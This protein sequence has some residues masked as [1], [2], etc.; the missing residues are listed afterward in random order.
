MFLLTD[1]TVMVQVLGVGAAGS[2]DWW[3]LTPDSSGSYVDG[4]WSQVGSLPADYGPGAYAAA[5][6]PDGR[7]AV[8]GGEFNNDVP[9]ESNL[10]A[11]YDPLTNTWT[12]VSPPNGGTGFWANI[13]DAPSEVLAD[14]RWLVGTAVSADYA[15]LDPATLTWTS[16][17]GGSK[18]DGN[19]EAGFTLLPNGKVRASTCSRRRVRREPP[20]RSIQ[21]PSCGRARARRRR[22]SSLAATTT[23]SGRSC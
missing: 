12:M 7:L 6:L 15:V 2:P 21:R 13:G 18:I 22:R 19:G 5:V 23:R 4:T 17:Y 3:R 8:E 20:R 16:N 10:G 14:G 1:G 11:I 9:A